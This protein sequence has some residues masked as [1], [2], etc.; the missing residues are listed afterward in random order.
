MRSQT[1][2]LL[3]ALGNFR[4]SSLALEVAWSKE[5][6]YL[7]GV[8]IYAATTVVTA[9]MAGLGLGALLAAV[10]RFKKSLE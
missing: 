7:L 9:F 4:Y 5:L 8:Y 2:L 6:S 3:Q 10:S 1:E